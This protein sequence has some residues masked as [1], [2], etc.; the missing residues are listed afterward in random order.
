MAV[1]LLDTNVL[2]ASASAR[3]EYHEPAREIVRGIDHGDLP[4]AIVT[5]YVVAETLNLARER[6]GPGP[7]NELLDRL[8]AG[9]HFEIVHAPQADF[10]AAQ[11]IFRRYPDLSFVDASIVAYMNRD[12][13]DYLYSFD[14]GFDG[15]DGLTRL[16]TADN[17]FN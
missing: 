7:A 13:I 3:D 8:I 6:L 2:F 15:V 1:A 11:A 16:D 14:D 9:A 10:N 12:D 5:N 4:D 17:P